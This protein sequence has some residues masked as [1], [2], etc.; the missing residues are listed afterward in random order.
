MRRVEV[1]RSVALCL[2]DAVDSGVIQVVSKGTFAAERAIGVDADT[3]LADSW[4]IQTLVHI[5]R[6]KSRGNRVY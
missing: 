2:T 1:V 6:E 4:V 3:V 5:Y